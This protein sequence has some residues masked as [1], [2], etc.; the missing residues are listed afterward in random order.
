MAKLTKDQKRKKQ[1]TLKRKQSITKA[2]TVN[3]VRNELK[4]LNLPDLEFFDNADDVIGPSGEAIKLKPKK[5]DIFMSNRDKGVKLFV[6]NVIE[7]DSKVIQTY[8][9]EVIDYRL[10]DDMSAVG[11]ELWCDEWVAYYKDR[12]LSLIGNEPVE[13]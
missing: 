4:S 10:K 7:L 11:D 12:D 13:F 9:V 8:S 6:Y 2:Q 5:G 1:Q 3:R